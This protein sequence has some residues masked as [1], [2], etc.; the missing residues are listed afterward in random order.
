[1]KTAKARMEQAKINYDN[2]VREVI[3]QVQQAISNIL[4]AKETVDSQEASVVQGVEALRLAQ[5]RLD[6]GENPAHLSDWLQE[7]HAG[8]KRETKETKE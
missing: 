6:A 5:E 3:L 2:G 1:M 7:E 4:E 8:E